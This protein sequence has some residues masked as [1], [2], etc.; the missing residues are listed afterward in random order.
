MCNDADEL[1]VIETGPQTPCMAAAMRMAARRLTLLY[2]TVMA[3]TGLR[4][5]QYSILS[6]LERWEDSRAPTLTELAEV[7][8]M[9]RSALGQTLR[10]LQRDGLVEI[11]KDVSDKRRHPVTLTDRGRQVL[12]QARP[13]WNM[14]QGQFF[15]SFGEEEGALLRTTLLQIAKKKKLTSRIPE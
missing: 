13:Y 7:L 5:T 11:S 15:D 14:A 3:T 12:D 2:D 6:Q 9:E 10:P 1:I 4:I 8:V